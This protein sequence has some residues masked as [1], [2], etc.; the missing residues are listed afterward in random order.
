[1][2]DL[3]ILW[4]TPSKAAL[5]AGL[6][7]GN[8]ELGAINLA[9]QLLCIQTVPEELRHPTCMTSSGK[10]NGLGVPLLLFS[11]SCSSASRLELENGGDCSSPCDRLPL[12]A[13]TSMVE[14]SS[15]ISWAKNQLIC[16]TA[17][18]SGGPKAG[19]LL[20]LSKIQRLL[21]PLA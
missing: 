17:F 8:Q 21:R 18:S 12:Q 3:E 2:I 19:P 4:E 5:R 6:V 15:V 13:F 11:P 10:A 1:M 14:N 16:R 20:F 9:G 7:S